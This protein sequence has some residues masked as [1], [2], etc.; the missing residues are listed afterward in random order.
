MRRI[1]TIAAW[2]VGGLVG[3]TLIT[4][5]ALLI[6][7]STGPGH[8]FVLGFLDAPLNAR[9]LQIE[10]GETDGAL[11]WSIALHDVTM[12]DGEGA[13][14]RART[15]YFELEPFA[16]LSGV[17]RAEAIET[18]ALTLIRMPVLPEPETPEPKKPFA[19][20]SIP[21]LPVDLHLT[22]IALSDVTLGQAVA[23]QDITLSL[24]GHAILGT[25]AVDI[26]LTGTQGEVTWLRITSDI[27]GGLGSFSLRLEEPR[28][29]LVAAITGDP[30]LGG[31][32]VS[33]QGSAAAGGWS[34]DVTAGLGG[35]GDMTL[36]AR[37][38]EEGGVP[39]SARFTPGAA[40]P[41][42]ART[43]MGSQVA[44]DL[45][46]R[47]D[48]AG[49]EDR[50][51]LRDIAL[52]TALAGL[53]GQVSLGESGTLDGALGVSVV[54]RQRLRLVAGGLTAETLRGDVTLSGTAAEPVAVIALLMRDLQTA[55]GSL[56]RVEATVQA[57]LD[58]DGQISFRMQG[59]G[60]KPALSNPQLA[61]LLGERIDL[62][63]RGGLQS[64]TGVLSLSEA[65][66]TAGGMAL[67][68]EGLRYGPGVAEGGASVTVSELAA[69][70]EGRL[71]EGTLQAR[72]DLARTDAATRFEITGA[73]RDLVFRD[74]AI[75]EQVGTRV[76]L[77]VLAEL[78]DT[79]AVRLQDLRAAPETGIAVATGT[80]SLDPQAE[81]L[82]G[83]LALQADDLAVF[84]TEGLDLAGAT[85]LT[86]SLSGSPA[87][88]RIAWSADLR[89]VRVNELRDISGG[90]T[91]RVVLEPLSLAAE[92]SLQTSEGP[93][94]LSLAAVPQAGGVVVE[95]LD[96]DLFGLSALRDPA[97]AS[98][99]RPNGL[100]LALADAPRL[101]NVLSKLTGAR[102]GLR[103]Q[104]TATLSASAAFDDLTWSAKARGF[105]FSQGTTQ[106][107]LATLES[108]GNLTPTDGLNARLAAAGITGL[109]QEFETL[110][111]E[112]A[113]PLD[114]LALKAKAVRRADEAVIEFAGTFAPG[115]LAV[116]R[117]RLEADEQSL[118]AAPFTVSL[119]G[120]TRLED[121]E[122]TIVQVADKTRAEATRREGTLRLSARQAPTGLRADMEA[123]SVPLSVLALLQPGAGLG[124]TLSGTARLDT[125]SETP[126]A[127]VSLQV[128]DLTDRRILS[129]DEAPPEDESEAQTLKKRGLG[130]TVTV[131]WDGKAARVTGSL[132]PPRG[133]P[134]ALN[135]TLPMGVGPSGLPQVDDS[136]RL[137]GSIS[138]DGP[139]RPLFALAPFPDHRLKGR[140]T[141]D[142]SVSGTLAAP[143]VAGTLG[144]SDGEYES[145]VAGT[146]FAP[147][148]VTV[149]T[150]GT[151]DAT[152][153][154]EAGD[155]NGGTLTAGGTLGFG[156]EDAPVIDASVE[157][158]RARL[159][160]RDDVNVSASGT[161]TLKGNR[162]RLDLQGKINMK[163]AR[164]VIPQSLPPEVVALDPVVVRDG[165]P[166]DPPA[167]E[168]EKAP[169]IPVYLDVEVE[170]PNETPVVGRG[171]D[172]IWTG[173][174]KVT[175]TAS[176]PLV[177]GQISL[178]R[179]EMALASRTLDL[180]T[181]R[182]TFT[183][184]REI[185]PLLDIRATT[186]AVDATAT[187]AIEGTASAPKISFSS[188][189]PLPR[190]AI[191]SRLLFGKDPQDLSSI[192]LAQ[193]ASATA[194]LT[195][196]FG[197]GEGFL[198]K[199]RR[200][201]GVDVLRVDTGGTGGTGGEGSDGASVTVGKNLSDD[202]YVGVRQGAGAGSTAVEVKLSLTDHIRLRTEISQTTGGAVGLD[203]EWE[204]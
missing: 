164:V 57:S 49:T 156:V 152:L 110:Q 176:L 19:V 50:V 10:V 87:K 198:I 135:L 196:T 162:E 149:S 93:A 88:P 8:R 184:G 79:G 170:L 12:R 63:L 84:G 145:L 35:Y 153:Q 27:E 179:G 74:P 183:G 67:R 20:P 122:L 191:I 195:G 173:A 48:R 65:E 85:T 186:K 111:A 13:F 118:S 177:T 192:E 4:A 52:E 125:L 60:A 197:G 160:R 24:A 77:R 194:T 71:S 130:G 175:G 189:P 204:Y 134:A 94:R 30:A 115:E 91:G 121:L 99:T 25:G 64:D 131:R 31:L 17:A 116:E 36:T 78:A 140:L 55:E 23:G 3:L 47:R 102:V 109:P 70:A 66:I 137:S 41:E 68:S 167:D 62:T 185:D 128:D 132:Q 142:F 157:M 16:L 174:V 105:G 6:F 38:V 193:L 80:L 171:L 40:L 136:A 143:K 89:G 82:S 146:Y 124:G 98:E 32:S 117:F 106:L 119:G 178:V 28:E 1:L 112:A 96:A 81:D 45:T 103:G 42:Q 155:G 72:I 107:Y 59:V 199:L 54:D 15:I 95:A 33:G 203:W 151:R 101:S 11:P 46:V 202:L 144:L 187:V 83:E 188:S 166:I 154:L 201:L 92:L 61:A 90:G 114:A 5:V 147:L 138:Y 180:S 53:G 190:D 51:V 34:I 22:G 159:V 169:P 139:V 163:E 165:V 86:V 56:E 172:S 14:L 181:G 26:D 7:L 18:D 161:L 100:S 76:D 150:D 97:L 43:A 37:P 123:K 39:V 73:A 126:G 104:A 2:T 120:E 133:E 129:D 127:T 182:I 200:Q 113:G 108:E 58:A 29:G 21:S 75:G 69:L 44:L 148:N 158:K 141:A 168:S 9:G